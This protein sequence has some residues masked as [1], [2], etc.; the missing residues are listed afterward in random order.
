MS[1]RIIVGTVLSAVAA[2]PP[3]WLFWPNEED[4]IRE[5]FDELSDLASK[6]ED[7]SPLSGALGIKNFA[8]LF[9][10]EVS[11]KTGSS[12]RLSGSYTNHE[13]ARRYGRLRAFAVSLD[14]RFEALEFQTMDE[15]YAKVTVRVRAGGTDKS[16]NKHSEDFRAEVLL[17][18]SKGE[19]KFRQFTYLR[20][21]P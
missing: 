18:K 4:R 3:L 15:D 8:D 1:K 2:F 21:L 6:T 7:T 9:C 16:G 10:E 13:L 17:Q 14:L 5:Q 11:L 12:K 19:W 20:S